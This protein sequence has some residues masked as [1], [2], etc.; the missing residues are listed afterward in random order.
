M[1]VYE[2]PI[3]DEDGNELDQETG[4]PIDPEPAPQRRN[5]VRDQL[6]RTEKERDQ[7]R[8]EAEE[9]RTARRE[10]A[11]VR[12]GLDP[13]DPR[14]AMFMK[15]YDGELDTEQIRSQAVEVG[16][17]DAPGPS[18]DAQAHA[19]AAAMAT[20]AMNAP[21]VD[22]SLPRFVADPD[23][24]AQA[25]AQARSQDDLIAVMNEWQSPSTS[26]ILDDFG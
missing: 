19:Q 2:N 18:A 16:F 9:G 1:P 21:V 7:L 24:Y 13:G 23:G 25:R 8:T 20:G 6:K 11:F 22:P 14:H 17:L 10:L 15:A 5:P 3:Y 26:Q 12:A 4:L